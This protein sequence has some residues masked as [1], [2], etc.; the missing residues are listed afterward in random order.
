VPRIEKKKMIPLQN[1][2]KFINKKKIMMKSLKSVL[3]SVVAL[4]SPFISFAHEGHGVVN[5]NSWVHY[6]TSS[7]HAG[8]VVVGLIAV[9]AFFVIYRNRKAVLRK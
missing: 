1:L 8:T 6:F 7:Q 2:I 3:F 4:F 9:I 5:N